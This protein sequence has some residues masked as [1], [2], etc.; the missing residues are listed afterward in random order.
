MPNRKT[1]EVP[2]WKLTDQQL[3]EIARR[4]ETD[5]DKLAEQIDRDE[6]RVLPQRTTL[7]LRAQDRQNIRAIQDLMGGPNVTI[8]EV[9]RRSLHLMA[10]VI[11]HQKVGGKVVLEKGRDREVVRFF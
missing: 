9:V 6:A 8:T 1:A 5:L 4:T 2:S 3:D 10:E 11:S 7:I